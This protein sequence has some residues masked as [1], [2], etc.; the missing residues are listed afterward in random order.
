MEVESPICMVPA[1]LESGE[2]LRV[3]M[4]VEG[5]V[6]WKVKEPESGKGSILLSFDIPLTKTR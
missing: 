3:G 4:Y 5:G 6:M 2:V 1:L